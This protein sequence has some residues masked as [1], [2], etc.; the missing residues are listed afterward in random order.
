MCWDEIK[1]CALLGYTVCQRYKLVST[2]YS[3]IGESL[4][5]DFIVTLGQHQTEFF[6]NYALRVQKVR[7]ILAF[8]HLSTFRTHITIY[9]SYTLNFLLGDTLHV[10]GGNKE[11]RTLG[12]RLTLEPLL[13]FITATQSK[14]CM[15]STLRTGVK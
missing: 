8:I 14:C 5:F 4:N 2:Y 1:K 6:T 13:Q 12:A 11:I 7:N 10:L 9:K 15:G 3:V